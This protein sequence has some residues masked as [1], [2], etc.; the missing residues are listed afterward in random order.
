MP[1]GNVQY[2]EFGITLLILD[3]Q[4]LLSSPQAGGEHMNNHVNFPSTRDGYSTCLDRYI[5]SYVDRLTARN[6]TA[7]TIKGYHVLI[8]HLAIIME[9]RGIRPE[10]LTVE[11]AAELVQGKERKRREPHKS[12]NIARRFV[13]YLIEIGGDCAA[14]DP[15]AG[16]PRS[17]A[18]RLRGLPAP[19]ARAQ[20]PLDLSLLADRRPV[21]RS[22]VW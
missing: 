21:P 17:A 16:R 15:E 11:M 4:C 12:A 13:E 1:H 22:S 20:R 2:R 9:D 6:Y 3:D 5:E 18:P 14:A 8:R 7:G 19:S 10:A